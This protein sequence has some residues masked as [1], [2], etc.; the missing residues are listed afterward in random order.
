MKLLGHEEQQ[1]AL[2]LPRI[3]VFR[4]VFPLHERFAALP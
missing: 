2:E 4:A 3:E 1:P